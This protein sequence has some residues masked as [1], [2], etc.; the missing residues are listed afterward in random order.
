VIVGFPGET[1][2]DFLETYRFIQE[3]DTS[4]LHVFTYSERP[5]TPAAEMPEAAPMEVR[6]QRNQML[7]ILSEKKRRHFHTQHLGQVR[8]VLFEHS[9]EKGRMSGFTDNYIRVDLPL[10]PACINTIEPVRLEALHASGLVGVARP[11]IA[12]R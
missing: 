10:E 4:Y 5:N 11:V 3:L 6:R 1:H 7:T 9:K 8:P 2:E 12:A